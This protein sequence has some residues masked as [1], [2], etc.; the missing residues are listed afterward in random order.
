MATDLVLV[1]WGAGEGL[2][3]GD[4]SGMCMARLAWQRMRTCV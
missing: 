3:G 2:P 1:V 4:L